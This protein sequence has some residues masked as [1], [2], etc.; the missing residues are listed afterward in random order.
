MTANRTVDTLRVLVLRAEFQT[1][2]SDS[3]TG[4][5]RFDRSVPAA[6]TID[7]P[8]HDRGYFAR[9]LQAL[10]SY[11]QAV[12]HG[13]L[14]IVADVPDPVI[15][16]PRSMS[17]YNPA[18]T[19]E[20]LQKG[21]ADLFRDAV[22]EGD[23]AGIGFRGHDVFVIFHAGVG[24][25]IALDYDP[26]PCDIPSVF[27]S[28]RDLADQLAGGDPNYAGIEVEGGQFR[29]E[30]GIVLPETESQEGYE[31]GLLGTGVVLFGFQ[32][33]LPALWNTLTG[34][35]GIGRWGMMDQG[36]GNFAGLLPAQPCAFSKVLLGW[37]S[38][39]VV[40]PGERVRLSCPTSQDS[41][42]VLKIP[43]ND[44]EYF[45]IENRNYDPNGDG[46]A[47]GW[48]SAG[49]I[50]H[51]RPDGTLETSQP[52]GVIVG[53]DE[54]DYGLP[55]SGILIWHIDED[56]VLENLARN[57]V[58]ADPEHRGVDLEE[59]DGAQDIG[60]AYGYLDPGYGSE[61]GVLH[62]AWF[63]GNEIALLANGSDSVRFGPDTYPNTRSYS[64]ANS[65][66]V[67]SGF[68]EVDTVMTFRV[69]NGRSLANWPIDFGEGYTPFPPLV[70]DLDGDSGSE[71]VLATR[72]GRIFAWKADGS[73]LIPNSGTGTRITLAGDTLTFPAAVF[74][75]AEEP[76]ALSQV[77][78]DLDGNGTDEIVAALQSGRIVV[79]SGSDTD[80]DGFADTLWT[81]NPEFGVPTAL[82]VMPNAG[83][84]L[85]VAGFETGMVA[86][87]GSDGGLLWSQDLE[88]GAVAGMC[89]MGSGA[90]NLL[91]VVMDEADGYGFAP[92]GQMVWERHGSEAFPKAPASGI[93][94]PAEG[95]EVLILASEGT[96]CLVRASGETDE[97][98]P[99]GSL[100]LSVSSP[101]LGDMDGDGRL[102]AVFTAGGRF[103]GLESNGS[104]VEF[105]PFPADADPDSFSAP[106]L[107]DVDGDGFMDMVA[108]GKSGNVVAFTKQG[109]PVEGF[110]LGTG[111]RNAVCPLATDL[112]NDG[113]LELAA[114]S[115]RGYVFVWNC[116]GPSGDDRVAWGSVN[117]DKTG[118]R[119]NGQHLSEP[120]PDVENWMPENLVYNYPNPTQG[121]FTTIRYRLEVPARVRITICDLIGRRIAEFD[122]P[123]EGQA[124]NEVVWP[125]AGIESGV[126]L[127]RVK[128]EGGQGTKVSIIKIAVVK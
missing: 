26:T 105:F 117:G 114:V 22:L 106:I 31:I 53:A 110:P 124:D 8:P 90:A 41:Q 58:N 127:A 91:V 64:G 32:I 85:V 107:A 42:K 73:A 1:D 66:L 60:E 103:L 79:W 69:E 27:L 83:E 5:G 38:P 2:D 68:S 86:A 13:Q 24:A 12:S 9:Q 80:A 59:A 82:L 17:G 57:L 121:E 55:G 7:P 62:D 77:L 48:D 49:T 89:T 94:V 100:P 104:P 81:R 10:S 54:Y 20:D 4:D 18:T 52:I 30:E 36:S 6:L 51:F 45:L 21:L 123:G 50:V 128:A 15:V 78:G 23:S 71:L 33:G 76:I 113:F 72:E 125:L 102:E 97:F 65:L 111:G 67:L 44:R 75:D 46:E 14:V 84:G 35:S 3:T 25:D 126:Y 88:G 96:G 11:F 28:T 92:S 56:V 16:L 34:H 39:R 115:E 61:T 109:E 118:S 43:I 112:N 95:P 108:A 101:A 122:G 37:E 63:E 87:F 93:F 120:A 98:F 74:A 19:D 70:G 40:L 29:V 47:L 119:N 99:V 116:D